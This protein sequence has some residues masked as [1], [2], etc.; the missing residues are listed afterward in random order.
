MHARPYS[1]HHF[2]L[3]IY[4]DKYAQRSDLNVRKKEK[5]RKKKTSTPDPIESI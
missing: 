1:V 4:P 3:G 2:I 5:R